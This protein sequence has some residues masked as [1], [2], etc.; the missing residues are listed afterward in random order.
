MK[1]YHTCQQ[2]SFPVQKDM[3]VTSKNSSYTKLTVYSYCYCKNPNA[4]HDHLHFNIFM[5][6]MSM[7]ESYQG[8]TLE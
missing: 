4:L 3:K 2:N 8:I 5:S 7:N 6:T 1:T